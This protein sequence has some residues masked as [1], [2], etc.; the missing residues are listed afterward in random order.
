[1]HREPRIQPLG[2]SSIRGRS[3]FQPNL[4]EACDRLRVL[5]GSNRLFQGKPAPGVGGGTAAG[6]EGAQQPPGPL[7]KS[8]SFH[9]ELPECGDNAGVFRPRLT[10]TEQSRL[11]C[12]ERRVVAATDRLSSESF[13]AEDSGGTD[14]VP[15]AGQARLHR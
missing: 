5:D 4:D 1:M 13:P 15:A 14:L 7:V 9:Y 2:G 10:K 3:S 11:G 8:F 12:V 6:V